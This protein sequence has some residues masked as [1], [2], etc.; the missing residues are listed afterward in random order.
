MKKIISFGILCMGVAISACSPKPAKTVA[1]STV[2]VAGNDV[3]T[4]QVDAAKAIYRDATMDA[5]Q[6]GHDIYYGTCTGCHG[7]KNINN[8]TTEQLPE[9]IENMAKKAKITPEEKDA[10]LKYVMGVKLAS[11]K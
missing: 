4:A 1:V 6:K 5:L 2:P 7:A 9:I 3:S 11:G 8:Y 10:V